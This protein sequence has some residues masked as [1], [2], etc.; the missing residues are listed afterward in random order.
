MGKTTQ[1]RTCVVC[2][3]KDKKENLSRFA[4][5]KEK[6]VVLDKEQKI[7]SRGFYVHSIDCINDENK[8][9][10]ASRKFLNIKEAKTKKKILL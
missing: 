2:G 7:Q 8:I 9:K 3:K 10:K 5:T 1:E 4:L 6:E